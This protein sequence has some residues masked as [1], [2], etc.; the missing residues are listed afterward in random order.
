MAPPQ[1][2]GLPLNCTLGPGGW[3]FRV[4]VGGHG[5]PGS[6]SDAQIF[7]HTDLR[8]KVKDSSISFPDSES[9]RIGGPKVNFFLLRDNAFPLMLWPYSN[10]SM[11]LKEMVFNYRI[12]R[13]R[14]VIENAFGILMFR[15][16]I[17]QSPLQQEHPVVNR[18]VMAC[19]VLH[20]LLRIRY[21]TTQQ[22]DFGGGPAYI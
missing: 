16:R 6:T 4:P 20:N 8:H 5:G 7:K 22:E 9:P 17:F 15:F 14:T 11:N 18:I 13:E 19:L 2:Q 3:T 1:Q 21:P 12:R 10:H